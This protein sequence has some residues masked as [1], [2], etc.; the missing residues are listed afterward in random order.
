[1]A[2]AHGDVFVCFQTEQLQLKLIQ[3]KDLNDKLE[4][5]KGTMERQV[6]CVCVAVLDF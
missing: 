2:A 3:E 1:M 4:L 6:L 5:N